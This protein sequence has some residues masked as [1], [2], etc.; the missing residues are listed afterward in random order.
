MTALGGL[1]WRDLR[2]QKADAVLTTNSIKG[3]R[4]M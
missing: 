1:D 4:K 3:L 2:D